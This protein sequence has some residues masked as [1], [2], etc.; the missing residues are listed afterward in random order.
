MEVGAPKMSST[1]RKICRALSDLSSDDSNVTIE[2]EVVTYVPRMQMVVEKK[3]R[4]LPVGLGNPWEDGGERTR[5]KFKDWGNHAESNRV[6]W[7]V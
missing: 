5:W 4:L 6:V 7:S 3:S 2:V 1:S